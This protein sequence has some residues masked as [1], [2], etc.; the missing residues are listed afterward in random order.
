MTSADVFAIYPSLRE[1]H[2]LITGGASGI[3]ASLVTH[4]CRQGSNVDFLDV[5]DEGA[6]RLL[7]E[8]SQETGRTPEFTHCDLR[9]IGA[10]RSAINAV[11]SARGA[12]DV[13][14]NNAARDDR[15]EFL[16]LEPD[17]WD[18]CLK[19]NLRHQIFAS[20]AVVHGMRERGGG[21]I[22]L[23]G[24]SSWMR[25]K[26]GFI[27]YTTSKAAINGAT[28]T[29]AREVGK[30]GIRVNS[31]VPGLIVTER[32]KQLWFSP[33]Q[34]EQFVQS[35]ALPVTLVPADAARLALFLAADDSR[36]CTG[37]NYIIDA[38]VF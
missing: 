12:V 22:L 14:V 7:A 38:G 6:E 36:G 18:E 35:Q 5:D 21:V 3:G 32:A 37:H 1:R 27:G 20:Q 29:L 30:Y 11:V 4:F 19:V 33:A 10:L 9:D 8:V 16:K 2:V 15:H 28:K 31:I 23:F 13:L 24:S 17:Y 26:P 34:I 25:G